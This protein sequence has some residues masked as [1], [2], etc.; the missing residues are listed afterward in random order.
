M[1][2]DL[3]H[4]TAS[5]KTLYAIAYMYSPRPGAWKGDFLYVHAEDAGEARLIY[6]RSHDPEM[7]KLRNV[8]ITG[9]APV[10][11][12]FANDDNGTSLSV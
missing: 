11:G 6:L 7:L 10:I 8:T 4:T 2:T 3:V 12:Y 1:K 5:G 9:V